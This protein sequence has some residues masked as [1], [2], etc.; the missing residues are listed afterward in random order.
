M[1]DFWVDGLFAGWAVEE[2][3][4]AFGVGNGGDGAWFA[5]H[6]VGGERGCNVGQF[7]GVYGGGAEGVRAEVVLFDV[8]GDRVVFVEGAGVGVAA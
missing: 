6:A 7:E 3:L 5:P 8:V 2:Y 1:G 4:V